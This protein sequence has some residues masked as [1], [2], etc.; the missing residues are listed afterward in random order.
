MRP[1]ITGLVL[2]YNGERLLG[3]CLESL[4]F[5][6]R[7]IVVDSYSTDSTETIAKEHGAVFVRRAWEGP[8]PQFRFAFE[9][10]EKEY[11]TGCSA[12]IKTN[13]VLPNSG[14]PFSALLKK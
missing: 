13:S 2:T 10:L 12:S 14:I 4:S 1:K 11:P 6:D 9:L 3:Q 8:G 5:C 7:V